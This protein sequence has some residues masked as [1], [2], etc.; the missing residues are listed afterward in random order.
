MRYPLFVK[1]A[2]EDA[3]L[4]IS[5]ASV[6]HDEKALVERVE[7][8]HDSVGTDAL[9]E[10]YID[11]RELYIGVLGNQRLQTLP[12]LEMTF[13][14]LPAGAPKIATEKVKW[15][16]NYQAKI[17]LRTEAPTDLDE[18]IT[19]RVHDLTR[20]IYRILGL[21]GYARLDLRL[22]DEGVPYLIEVNPNPDLA[23]DDLLAEAAEMVGMDYEKLL[24]KIV[25]LGL[26][27]RA[28]WAQ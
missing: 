1:S 20:R 14:N 9:I 11:G 6:V 28:M 21:S 2:T 16:E 23:A 8:I 24:K 25:S 15:D 5:Q 3:S 10:E 12:I 18:A 7:F 26:R 13:P 19:R 4:G 27:Y 22:T 17:G